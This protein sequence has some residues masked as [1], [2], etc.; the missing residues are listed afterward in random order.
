M[1]G[2]RS[3]EGLKEKFYVSLEGHGAKQRDDV[4]V[5]I[6]IYILTEV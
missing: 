5:Y 3:D 1:L 2:L 4:C 6:Y